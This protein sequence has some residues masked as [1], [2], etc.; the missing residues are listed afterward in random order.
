[1]VQSDTT[2]HVLGKLRKSEAGCLGIPLYI[3]FA[4]RSLPSR[5]LAEV[6]LECRRDNERVVPM[7]C[8]PLP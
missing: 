2:I 3:Y 6:C 8:R 1:M 7:T 5:E 4:Y